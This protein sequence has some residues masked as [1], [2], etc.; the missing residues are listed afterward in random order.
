M[1][2]WGKI[3][4]EVSDGKN[5]GLEVRITDKYSFKATENKDL[6]LERVNGGQHVDL[7]SGHPKKVYC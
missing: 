2:T 1:G 4:H 5:T 6:E 3:L 7:A